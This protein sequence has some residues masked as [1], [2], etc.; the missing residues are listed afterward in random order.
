MAQVIIVG[1]KSN[2][3]NVCTSGAAKTLIGGIPVAYVGSSVSGDPL[4]HPA[5]SIVSPG[6]N[7]KTRLSDGTLIACHGAGT[8]CGGSMQASV[9]KTRIGS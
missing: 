1:D 2:H 6:P 9:L 7:G 8:A 4:D 3:G 5:N